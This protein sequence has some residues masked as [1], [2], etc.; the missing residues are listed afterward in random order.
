MRKGISQKVSVGDQPR[1]TDLEQL[2][3]DG[4]ATVVN[5]RLPGEETPLTPAEEQALAEKLGLQYHNLPISLDK[6]DAAQVKELRE[7][8]GNSPGPDLRSLWNGTTRV[9]VF[10]CRFRCENRFDFGSDVLLPPMGK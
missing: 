9:R 4:V 5:L 2:K 7:I 8:L 6:L 1:E 3:K 10:A